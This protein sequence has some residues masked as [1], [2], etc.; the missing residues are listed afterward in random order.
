MISCKELVTALIERWRPETNTFHLV[1]GEATITLEDVEVLTGL[2][3]TGRPLTVSSDERLVTDI[4]EQWLGV[5]P[6]PNAIQG[7]TVRVSW[8][9]R[10]F[11]RLPDGATP[12][13][14]IYHARA[15]TWVLVARVLLADRNE[16][17][18]QVHLLQLIGDPRVASTYSWG[19]AVLAW[20][21]KVMGRAAFFSAGSMGAL[22]TLA[23]SPSW[24]SYGPWKD[25]PVLQS[26]TYMVVPPPPPPPRAV[27]D[28]FPRGARWLPVIERHQH[29]V[30][31]H[32][33]DIRYAL[34]LCMDFV[35]RF[36]TLSPYI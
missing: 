24:S 4:C 31:M 15:Y 29:R 26:G 25:S 34:D 20:L 22:V 11:D 30:A 23:D 6:P 27:D 5:Q 13:V 14:I 32:L 10:L 1:P 36:P 35:V 2:P 18:I 16:D 33:E 7:R 3:T 28:T 12:E 17:H 19:S 21:Y 9:K 8:V